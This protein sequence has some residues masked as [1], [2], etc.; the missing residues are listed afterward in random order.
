MACTEVND[1]SVKP[2]LTGPFYVVDPV[3]EK[4]LIWGPFIGKV[5]CQIYCVWSRGLWESSPSERDDRRSVPILLKYKVSY[6]ENF[7]YLLLLIQECAEAQS[8]LDCIPAS[9][10][11]L[12]NKT[13]GPSGGKV[14]GVIDC[15][16]AVANTFDSEDRKFLEK[17][18]DLLGLACDWESRI[19]E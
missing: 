2:K 3:N 17:L 4:Q 11:N 6:R 16:S 8:K 10:Q 15:D 7:L 14:I 1:L 13:H 9:S 19:L 5:A 18:A 12:A